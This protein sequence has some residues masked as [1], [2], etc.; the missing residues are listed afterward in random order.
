[1]ITGTTA[2]DDYLSLIIFPFVTTAGPAILIRFG[3][4]C[5]TITDVFAVLDTDRSRHKRVQ[6]FHS[7]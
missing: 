6:L 2:S 3:Q 7:V 4:L 1:M 5:Q